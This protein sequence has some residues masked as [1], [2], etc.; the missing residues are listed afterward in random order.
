MDVLLFRKDELMILIRYSQIPIR[1]IVLNL[2]MLQH[3]K[4]T[5]VSLE[6][7]F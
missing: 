6:Q 5:D 7:W 4:I 3:S 1:V 2:Q